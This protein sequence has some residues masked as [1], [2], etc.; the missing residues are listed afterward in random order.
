MVVIM[1]GFSSG[2]EISVE[3]KCKSENKG[4][5]QASWLSPYLCRGSF[6][7]ACPKSGH[8]V[9]TPPWPSCQHWAGVQSQQENLLLRLAQGGHLAASQPGSKTL[10]SSWV[11]NPHPAW[12][13]LLSCQLIGWFLSGFPE[14]A[15]GLGNGPR[16]RNTLF[17]WVGIWH[18]TWRREVQTGRLSCSRTAQD[19]C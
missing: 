19:L 9:C 8:Q 10:A 6:S 7:M 11:C 18:L 14:H 4:L 12:A 3:I 1:V 16:N 13:P 17:L 2:L 15:L 5:I